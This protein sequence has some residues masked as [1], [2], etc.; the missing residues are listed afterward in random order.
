MLILDAIMSKLQSLRRSD[1][2]IEGTA[3]VLLTPWE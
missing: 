3:D 1:M 2:S